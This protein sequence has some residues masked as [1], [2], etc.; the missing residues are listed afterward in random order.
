M[1]TAALFAVIA[2]IAACASIAYIVA[3]IVDRIINR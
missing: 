2:F 1:E 3:F